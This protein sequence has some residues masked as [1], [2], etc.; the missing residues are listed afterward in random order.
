MTVISNG[1]KRYLVAVTKQQGYLNVSSYEISSDGDLGMENV[2][3]TIDGEEYLVGREAD[4]ERASISAFNHI[5]GGF[6]IV[7]KGVAR[8]IR[9]EDGEWNKTTKGLKI[10]SG[11][12]LDDGR[13]SIISSN[14][15]GSGESSAMSMLDVT[16]YMNDG[17]FHGVISAHK[18][19][20]Y[21]GILGMG[22]KN[23]LELT[24]WHYRN[25][26]KDQTWS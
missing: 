22:S 7:G 14:V 3:H 21:G 18:T 16:G 17:F 26:Y 6:V 11:Y 23:F 13:P 20:D 19:K 24:F 4:Y 10:V 2:F 12:I 15:L 1:H 9:N 5:K 8:E 25:P